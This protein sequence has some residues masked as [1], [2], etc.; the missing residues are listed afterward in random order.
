MTEWE[1]ALAKVELIHERG[2]KCHICEGPRK[3]K[4]Q[5]LDLRKGVDRTTWECDKCGVVETFETLVFFD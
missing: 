2:R 5:A 4:K 1:E 3:F